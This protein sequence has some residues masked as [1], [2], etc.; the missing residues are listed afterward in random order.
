MTFR[1]IVFSAAVVGII[2]GTLYGVFQQIQINPIIYAAEVYEVTGSS[3]AIAL[4]SHDHA[5]GHSHNHEAWAP[6]QGFE[7]MLSTLVANIL[8]AM[9]FSILLISIISMP[10][11]IYNLFNLRNL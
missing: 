7:R 11:Y 4:E 8:V 9:A 3:D 1:N 2:A 6:E 5:D 10:V